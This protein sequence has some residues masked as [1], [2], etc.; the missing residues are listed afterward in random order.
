MFQT[1][2][3]HLIVRVKPNVW[4]TLPKSV[5]YWFYHIIKSG[6]LIITKSISQRT[7]SS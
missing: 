4:Y 2:N 5:Y 6:G 3:Q 7:S 1:T